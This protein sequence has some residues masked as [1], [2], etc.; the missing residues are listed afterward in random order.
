MRTTPKKVVLQLVGLDGNAFN[1][2]AHFRRAEKDQGWLD[3]EINAVV[4]EATKANYEHLLSIL[5]EHTLAP[6]SED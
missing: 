1:L 2:L 5:I 4:E 6:N 3:E